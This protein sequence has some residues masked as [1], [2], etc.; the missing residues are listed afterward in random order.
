MVDDFV[1]TGREVKE[2]AAPI[3]SYISKA[4]QGT[5]SNGKRDLVLFN[6][7]TMGGA[8]FGYGSVISG[9]PFHL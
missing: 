5:L 7:D 4:L 6:E 8:R 1:Y 9:E 3:P 2:R